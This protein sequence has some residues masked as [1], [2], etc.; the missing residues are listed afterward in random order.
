VNAHAVANSLAT[1][2]WKTRVAVIGYDREDRRSGEDVVR[3][4]RDPPSS[5]ERGAGLDERAEWAVGLYLAHSEK[6]P[7]R[8]S[9]AQRLVRLGYKKDLDSASPRT[10]YLSFLVSTG[11]TSSTGNKRN[12]A[13][14]P[15]GVRWKSRNV[16]QKYS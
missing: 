15:N 16:R 7:R 2:I 14:G 9:A 12:L 10:P 13:R 1:G 3:R 5:A 8:N 6:S 11:M 4:W